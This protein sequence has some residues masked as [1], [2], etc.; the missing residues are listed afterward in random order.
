MSVINSVLGPLDTSELGFTLTHEH[1]WQSA[2]GVNGSYPEFF[3]RA[4]VIERAVSLLTEAHNEGVQTI[5][6]VTTLDLGR[7][8][9]LAEDVSRRTGVNVIAATGFWVDIPRIFWEADPDEVAQLFIK[10]INQ[11]ID[12]TGI[13]AGIIKVANNDSVQDGLSQA[14]KVVLK[15]AARALKQTGVP[16]T[17]HTLATNRTGELQVGVFE[18]EGVDLSRVCIGHSDGTTDVDYL[19]GLLKRGVWLGLDGYPGGPPPRGNPDWEQRTA[20]AKQLVDA[21]YGHRIMLSHDWCVIKPWGSRDSQKERQQRN[22]DGYLFV[23][24]HVLPRL[25]EMGLSSEML[26]QLTV[27][28]PRQFFEGG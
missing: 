22:P 20:L 28:N 24:R 9:R 6:D 11:G 17:T 14:G 2:A 1:V 21:G 15:A 7:D 16:I 25:E 4:D 5:V 27:E 18:S 26:N 12:G 10:E 23:T 19:L 8:I 3:D 13:K